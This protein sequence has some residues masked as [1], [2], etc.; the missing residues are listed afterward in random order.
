M[1]KIKSIFLPDGNENYC[2]IKAN[3]MYD[4]IYKFYNSH[5]FKYKIIGVIVL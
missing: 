3:D 1:F 2:D 4:A 5:G